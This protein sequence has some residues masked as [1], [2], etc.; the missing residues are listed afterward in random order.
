MGQAESTVINDSDPPTVLTE[1]SLSA[2]AEY[3]HRRGEEANIVVL[4][5]AGIST[6]AGIPDFRSPKTGLYS[7]LERLNLPHAEAVFDISYFR[8][9]PEPFYVLAQELYP[10]RFHPTVSHAFISLLAQKG[11]LLKL[12]TQ[13]IDC[14]E[15]RAGVPPDKIVEAHGSFASQRCIEC[16]AEFPDG[17]MREHVE[18]GRVP[19]CREP[20]CDGIVK[21]DIVFFGEALPAVF[22]DS[23]PRVADAGL[24][25]VLGT[26][27]S[28]EPFASLPGAAELGTPRLLINKE[29]VGSLGCRAD[30]VLA[31]G[32]C[33]DGI[34][35]LADEL[36]WRDELE[37][38]WRRVVGDD[39]AE[40]QLRG[41]AEQE[42]AV[43][44]EVNR[45][46]EGVESA[47]KLQEP[48]A[49][50]GGILGDHDAEKGAPGAPSPRPVSPAPDPSDAVEQ[51]ARA[52][53]PA[54]T[55]AAKPDTSTHSEETTPAEAGTE[56]PQGRA[57]LGRDGSPI[58]DG[59]PSKT[60]EGGVSPRACRGIDTSE[61]RQQGNTAGHNAEIHEPSQNGRPSN[62]N[63]AKQSQQ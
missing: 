7:N 10:G 9:H 12:F 45:L 22:Y 24:V 43:E 25:I 56:P 2:V 19:R 27:L 14:L 39:E 31:L 46:A 41:A 20:D 35:R 32:A 37:A 30:D 28:V 8:V 62:E 21:P 11:L 6:A 52:E 53:T 16:R 18:G 47:L 57:G 50:D 15:R 5:G 3:I 55:S 58:H 48:S 1:R 40:R 42:D 13:N 4:T 38:H 54:T 59:T 34:R 44:D 17:A 36:G 33:D 26:S 51:T 61:Q 63:T 29:R 23:W 60:A 49:Q